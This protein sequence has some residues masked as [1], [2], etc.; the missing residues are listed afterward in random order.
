MFSLP[1]DRLKDVAATLSSET[2]S[3]NIWE[4]Y[5]NQ[6][7]YVPN[8]FLSCCDSI[9]DC[10]DDELKHNAPPA[11]SGLASIVVPQ[12]C[13][14]GLKAATDGLSL[15]YSYAAFFTEADSS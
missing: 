10:S 2:S 15:E 5:E 4:P 11:E 3:A 9:L 12:D 6:T 1:K 13:I 14:D 7:V 8:H